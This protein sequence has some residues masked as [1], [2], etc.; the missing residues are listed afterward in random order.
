M[1]ADGYEQHVIAAQISK[2]HEF[3]FEGSP[4]R[5]GDTPSEVAREAVADKL[6]ISPERLRKI[7]K[8]K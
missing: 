8:R 4:F 3:K 1:A 6:N 2:E 5:R 7:L